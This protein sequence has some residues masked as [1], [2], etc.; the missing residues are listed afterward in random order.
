MISAHTWFLRLFSLVFLLSLGMVLLLDSF[1]AVEAEPAPSK[2]QLS[3]SALRQM[4]ALQ[5]EKLSRSS[6][7]RKIDSQLLSELKKYRGQAIAQGV[8]TLKT[9][10]EIDQ[11]SR[12]LV[13]IQAR[14]TDGLLEKIERSG[15][16]IINSFAE[17]NAIRAKL[18]LSQL[19][20][21]ASLDDIKF[22]QPALHTERSGRAMSP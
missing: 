20:V 16:K 5:R 17:D 19:E 18:P 3:E 1:C 13:D 12:V 15:G 14:V 6:A 21:L 8:P 9:G 22:I 4:A 10:V 11:D 7:Q 2:T